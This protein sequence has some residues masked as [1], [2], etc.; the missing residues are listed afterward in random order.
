MMRVVSS[1]P[2]RAG[3]RFGSGSELPAPR[4]LGLLPE[5]FV[6]VNAFAAGI[7]SC[8][9]NAPDANRSWRRASELISQSSP[10]ATRT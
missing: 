1:V 5:V 6:T 4:R 8:H 9:S 2:Q 7:W 3:A 10:Y